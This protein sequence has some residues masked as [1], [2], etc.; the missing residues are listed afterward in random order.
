MKISQILFSLT[1]L[2]K[3][4]SV[5]LTMKSDIYNKRSPTSPFGIL[6]FADILRKLIL[7][8]DPSAS[9]LRSASVARLLIV[10]LGLLTEYETFGPSAYHLFRKLLQHPR[11]RHQS[12][13]YPTRYVRILF[14]RVPSASYQYF[15]F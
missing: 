11:T 4:E 6:S 3:C 10:G 2:Q 12:T 1:F 7:R 15:V 14:C 13:F 8:Q 9:I 5:Y